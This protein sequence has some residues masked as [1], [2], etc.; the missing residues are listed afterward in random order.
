MTA[1]ATWAT[2]S[3]ATRIIG[4]SAALRG[5]LDMVRIVAPTDATVLIE[6]ETGTGKEL[7]AEVSTRAVTDRM[8]RL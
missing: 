8:G 1:N 5:V 7:I 3:P 2:E 4:D 6:G